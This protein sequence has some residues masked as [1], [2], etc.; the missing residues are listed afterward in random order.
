M[1]FS[2]ALGAFAEGFSA[3]VSHMTVVRA[4]AY[5][6]EYVRYVESVVR[7]SDEHRAACER[8]T[9]ASGEPRL[10]GQIR[11]PGYVGSNFA[12]ASIRILCAAQVHHGPELTE[13]RKASK[14]SSNGSLQ[15]VVRP[16]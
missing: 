15:R 11:W 1:P 9:G 13:P 2:E 5:S 3:N 10:S 12:G 16:N 8:A 6:V 7:V 14:R 4:D